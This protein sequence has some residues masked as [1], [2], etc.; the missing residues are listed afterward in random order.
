MKAAMTP[1]PAD[2]AAATG[3]SDQKQSAS[4]TQ[5]G[6]GGPNGAPAPTGTPQAQTSPQNAA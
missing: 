6:Q 2:P 5:G 4:A 3:T 1:K